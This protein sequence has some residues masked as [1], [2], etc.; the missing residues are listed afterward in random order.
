MSRFNPNSNFLRL[1]NIV[2]YCTKQESRQDCYCIWLLVDHLMWENG[3]SRDS[4]L[5]W[6]VKLGLC[7]FTQINSLPDGVGLDRILCVLA[8]I[9]SAH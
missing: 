9:G 6:P 4:H 1:K 8:L 7:L 5:A 2:V 3:L